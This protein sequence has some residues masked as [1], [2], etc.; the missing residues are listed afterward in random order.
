MRPSSTSAYD[1]AATGMSHHRSGRLVMTSA[2]AD[3]QI[4][5]TV[6]W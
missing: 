2:I 6:A 4:S 3:A 1:A 5:M